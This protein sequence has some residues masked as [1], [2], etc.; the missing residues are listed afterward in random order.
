MTNKRQ[1][2]PSAIHIHPPLHIP[3]PRSPSPISHAPSPTTGSHPRTRRTGSAHPD[4]TV[5]F[6]C[7]ARDR[8]FGNEGYG[9]VG[10]E[11]QGGGGVSEARWSVGDGWMGVL[12]CAVGV[13]Q[14]GRGR[15]VPS[16]DHS[17]E[18]VV[19]LWVWFDLMGELMDGL[20][21][22]SVTLLTR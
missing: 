19:L 7:V 11:G 14:L 6:F 21:E 5:H 3:S 18:I 8:R 22:G 4:P 16:F 17:L 10:G 1:S 20:G 12:V 2:P 15:Y 13:G 9:G